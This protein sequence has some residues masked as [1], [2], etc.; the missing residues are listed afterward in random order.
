[1]GKQSNKHAVNGKG[2]WGKPGDEFKYEDKMDRADPNFDDLDVA[3]DFDPDVYLPPI[4]TNEKFVRVVADMAAFK[5]SV[6]AATD[7]YFAANDRD[8]FRRC[9]DDLNCRLHHQ[10]VGTIV[11]RHVLGRTAEERQCVKP[12]LRFLHENDVLTSAH[13]THSFM[14]LFTQLDELKIDYPEAATTLLDFLSAMVAGEVVTAADDASLRA[15]AALQSDSAQLAKSKKTIK[16]IVVEYFASRDLDECRRSLAELAT[17]ALHYEFVKRLV[18]VSLDHTPREREMASRALAELNGDKDGLTVEQVEQGFEILLS[19]AED[20]YVDVP[21]VLEYLSCFLSRAVSDECVSPA[22][23]VRASQFRGAMGELVVSQ[24]ELLLKQ[25][26]SSG[27]M[28]LELVWGAGMTTFAALKVA[29]AVLVQE[30]Y[31]SA[32]AVNASQCFVELKSPLYAH[33]LVKRLFVVACD[34]MKSPTEENPKER[35]MCE[36]V[37]QMMEQH[38]ITQSQLQ[39]GFRRVEDQLADIE[40][41]SPGARAMFARVKESI[42]SMMYVYDV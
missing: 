9:I 36:L 2:S 22:F 27:S 26:K 8:E 6:R 28:R 31:D 3:E 25:S 11:M 23:L 17:P 42:Q 7:E 34:S 38:K 5:K 24:T 39:M 4:A 19:R 35:L 29:V 12:L 20:L 33:E 21:R 41:D 30:Y 15:L 37:K 14:S 16:D 10:E 1:M 18:S 32:D 40:L 13:I